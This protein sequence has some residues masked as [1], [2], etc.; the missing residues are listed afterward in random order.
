MHDIAILGAGPA[1]TLAAYECA[2]Q[3]L[4]AVLLE[5]ARLPRR[6]VCGGGLSAKSL[7]IL[8]FPLDGVREQRIV[9]GWVAYRGDALEVHVQRPGAMVCRESF[10]AFLA[11]QAVGAG[12]ELVEGFELETV[13]E[14]DDGYLLVP[15]RGSSIRARRLIAADGVNS[16]VRRRLFPD[17]HAGTVAALEARV[18]PAA[19]ASEQVSERC[20]FDFG[21]VEAGY[22][23]IFPKGDH[24]N[25]GVYRYRKTQG[26]RDLR[27]VLA[28]FL[29]TNPFLKD[30]TVLD[31][32]GARI[33][34]SPGAM[35]LVNRG[36]ILAGDAAG[37]GDA[38]FG[39]GIYCALLSGREAAAAM[40][41]NVG[42]RT[43]LSAYDETMRALRRQLSASALMAAF[44]YRF[45]R[46][47]FERM[48]R[49]PY[50][51]RLFTGVITG[52]V[53]PT[54]CLARAVATAPYWM[55]AGGKGG[56]AVGR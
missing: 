18:A 10:D 37:L 27:A 13:R 48:A 45:P 26:S 14:E 16:I 8:P 19:W 31:I 7:G 25:V 49:S 2:R 44:V 33:P 6:K 12:A 21:A 53:R 46:F 42:G 15:R 29:S 35:S 50:A 17:S 41:A 22:G 39:E 3:G 47:A 5:K 32:A 24:F 55:L 51:S 40:V 11:Q 54:E 34:V 56:R 23:W 28:E 1:G 4:R 36:A 38:L 30:A 52:E 43:P 20:L 9:S